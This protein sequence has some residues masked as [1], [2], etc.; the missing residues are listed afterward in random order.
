[1][2]NKLKN[3]SI[4]SNM[5]ETSMKPPVNTTSPQYSIRYFIVS[6]YLY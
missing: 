5:R 3:K 2:R 1:M 6:T 4:K